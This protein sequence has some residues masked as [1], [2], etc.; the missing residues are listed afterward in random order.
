M[1]PSSSSSSSFR[2]H[3]L[4]LI[5]YVLITI[6][7]AQTSF[8]PKALVLPL[9]KHPSTLQYI[10]KLGQRTPLV[11][12]PL[13]VDIGG[14]FLWNDCE[15]DFVSSSYNTVQCKTDA[16]SR[17][18][19]KECGFCFRPVGP[20]CGNNSCKVWPYNPVKFFLT[21]GD[22]IQDVVVLQSTD[23]SNPGRF[24]KVS[25]FITGC[26]GTNFLEKLAD[27]VKGMAGLGRGNT[28]MSSQLADA[29]SFPRKFAVCLGEKGV[30]IFGDGPYRFL[31]DKS[32]D[33]AKSLT[34]TPLLINK[35]RTGINEDPSPEYFIG[36][37]SIK[38]NNK[39]LNVNTTLL[40]INSE[41]YGGTK[42][43][44]TDPY[45]VLESSIYAAI[46]TAF[47]KEMARFQTVAPVAP[48]KLCYNST[49]IQYN[50]QGPE[51]PWIDLVLQSSKVYWR[52]YGSNSMVQVRKDVLCLGFI[53]GGLSFQTSR[54]SIGLVTSIILGGHQI[55]NNLMQFDLP[56]SKLGF[57][58]SLSLHQTKCSGFNFTSTA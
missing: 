57:S 26:T 28:A 55:E 14:Q 43:S 18:G 54:E 15:T 20:G 58:S 16:C 34:Y 1:A 46:T 8:R 40:K 10:T 48:F 36:V 13:V 51:V 23:G 39:Q 3:S 50:Q 7:V 29:F 27:G 41:G 30:V 52:I 12:L 33:Y 32:V 53:D 49:Q 35:V 6:S 56:A 22:L 25:K 45:T 31:P 21:N 47:R 44:S 24:V 38:M 42:I 4:L 17:A 2:F 37:K 19:S 5:L 9:T 11:S